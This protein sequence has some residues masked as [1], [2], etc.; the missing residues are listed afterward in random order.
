VRPT[1]TNTNSH[2]PTHKQTGSINI[3][4]AA[5]SAQC[6]NSNWTAE[7]FT[8]LYNAPVPQWQ[9]FLQKNPD[10]D[11]DPEDCQNLMVIKHTF[12]VQFSWRSDWSIRRVARSARRKNRTLLTY[13]QA[14]CGSQ[15][16]SLDL[17]ICVQFELKFLTGQVAPKSGSKPDTWKPHFYVKLLTDRLTEKHTVKKTLLGRGINSRDFR[18]NAIILQLELQM[19][20]HLWFKMHRGNLQTAA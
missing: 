11:P 7:P 18:K 10:L 5:A 8:T 1:H 3:H 17:Y 12:A 13:F 2:P 16:E 19:Q 4:C 14:R 15:I 6:N 20:V 9:K